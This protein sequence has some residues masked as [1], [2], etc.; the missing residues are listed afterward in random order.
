MWL[1]PG[2][3]VVD[4][5]VALQTDGDGGGRQDKG[6]AERKMYFSWRNHKKRGGEEFM[7]VARSLYN[8]KLKV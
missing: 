4:S 3:R 6:E 2:K 5:V 1:W 8:L 7:P